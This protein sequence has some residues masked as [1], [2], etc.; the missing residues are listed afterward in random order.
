M[1]PLNYGLTSYSHTTSKFIGTNFGGDL[2]TLI[3]LYNLSFLQNNIH[4]NG[5]Y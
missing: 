4:K 2:L 3:L 5:R 1:I